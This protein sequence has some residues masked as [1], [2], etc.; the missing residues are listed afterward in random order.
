MHLDLPKHSECPGTVNA[1]WLESVAAH[2]Q[3]LGKPTLEA[4]TGLGLTF[5]VNGVDIGCTWSSNNDFSWAVD[6]DNFVATWDQGTTQTISLPG[7]Q[8]GAGLDLQWNIN[9]LAADLGIDIDDFA[10]LIRLCLGSWL[11]ERGGSFGFGFAALFGL[12]HGE[13]ESAPRL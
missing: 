2:I 12:F 9:T 10:L 3:L 4:S 7:L 8:F 6:I 5:S 11:A 1:T 13:A